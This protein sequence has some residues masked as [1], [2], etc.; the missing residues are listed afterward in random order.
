MTERLTSLAAI[1][2]WL[3]IQSSASDSLLTD[4]IDSASRFVLNYMNR[5]SLACQSYTE[6]FRGNGKYSVLLKNWPILSVE[7]VGVNG[8]AVPASTFDSFGKPTDGYSPREPLEAPNS[9]DLFGYMFLI[10]TPC[11]VVYTAGYRATEAQT[12]PVDP[13]QL[14]PRTGGQWTSDLS[15]TIADVAAVKVMGTPSTGQYSVDDWGTYTFANADVGKTAAI[16]YSY[17]PLDLSHCVRELV[18]EWYNRKDRIGVKSKS[19]GG[20]ET[21]TFTTSDMNDSIRGVIQQYRNVVPM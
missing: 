14:E 19:L 2:D 17:C 7:S 8:N 10:N 9:V 11:Q 20:Q 5:P 18:G 13:Y 16:T 1:K 12:I 6:R 21:V 15:V 3:G 4:L